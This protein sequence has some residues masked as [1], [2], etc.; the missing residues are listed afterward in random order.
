MFT[1]ILEALNSAAHFLKIAETDYR[2]LEMYEQAQ[3]V[4]Y[5]LAV[6]YHNLGKET[7]RDKASQRHAD[8]EERRKELENIGIDGEVQEVLDLVASVGGALASRR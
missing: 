3:D 1:F 2:Q 8:L 5:F 4:V 7:E 6:V